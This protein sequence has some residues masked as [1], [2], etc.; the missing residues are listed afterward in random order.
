MLCEIQTLLD[1]D[2]GDSEKEKW[3]EGCSNFINIWILEK[4]CSF[5]EK[6]PQT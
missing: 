1:T 4:L 2:E 6:L 3:S 5:M